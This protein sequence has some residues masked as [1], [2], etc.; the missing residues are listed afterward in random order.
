MAKKEEMSFWRKSDFVH[1]YFGAMFVII[2]SCFVLI[3]DPGSKRFAI[4]GLIVGALYLIFAK[5]INKFLWKNER[6]FRYKK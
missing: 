2:A 6:P 1:D 3:L 4:T 5:K